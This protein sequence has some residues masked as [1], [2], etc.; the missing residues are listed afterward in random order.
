M[1]KLVIEEITCEEGYVSHIKIV[2]QSHR[3]RAFTKDSLDS[4]RAKDGFRLCSAGCPEVQSNILYVRGS[5]VNQDNNELKVHS[6]AWLNRVRAAIHEY[7]LYNNNCKTCDERHC[8][9]CEI[10]KETVK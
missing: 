6:E 9:S 8:N 5:S 3:G 10:N 7:Y 1:R 4:F 2:E